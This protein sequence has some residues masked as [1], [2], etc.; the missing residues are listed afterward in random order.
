M[1]ETFMLMNTANTPY[2]GL[3]RDIL[4]SV[5]VPDPPPEDGHL[6]VIFYS[7][8]ATVD[9]QSTG[10]DRNPQNLANQGYI[11]IAPQHQDI[12]AILT[13][14]E[15]H[16]NRP[17]STLERV[18]DFN[19]LG[20]AAVVD[21]IMAEFNSRD[22]GSTVY[23]AD[24]T[25]PI[26]AGH[27]QGAFTA[28]MLIGV[29]SARP[30]FSGLQANPFFEAAVLFSPQ[31]VPTTGQEDPGLL[32]DPFF[33]PF[34]A[35]R[36]AVREFYLRDRV[37]ND[38][39]G[40]YWT[41]LYATTDSSGAVVASSWDNVTIPVLVITGT[42]D[43]G[44]ALQNYTHR[45]DGFDYSNQP[46]R[47]LV[48]V[49]GADHSE[50]GG[51]YAATDGG[52]H[53]TIAGIAGDFLDAY[54]LGDPG[55]QAI[56]NDVDGLAVRYPLLRE[57]FEAAGTGNGGAANGAGRVFGDST[58]ETLEGS[59]TDDIV[60]GRGG[61]DTLFG[62]GGDD[63]LIGG[64]GRDTMSGGLGD[65]S[66]VFAP[67][68]TGILST[69]RDRISDFDDF[70]NDSIDLSAFGE[71]SYMG[72]GAFTG[73]NQVRVVSSG[74][75]VLIQINTDGDASAEAVIELLNT[76]LSQVGIDDFFP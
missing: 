67:G 32:L 21:A 47:H 70:G 4:V 13:T 49:E 31:G 29:Q 57:I 20:N 5:F 60:Y 15:F 63:F 17:L 1:S 3:H 6:P 42:E 39:D 50:M 40:D 45:R 14:D 12:G 11:V 38:N 43:A 34:G 71:L 36:Q 16:R 59:A 8:G 30:E 62:A 25:T 41:G 18:E 2:A 66:F 75:S 26:I 69:T 53:E 65:D 64:A 24:L 52:V 22:T 58:A 35:S 9:I 56:I 54:V 28:Q 27:S 7:H 61:N 74:S 10:A 23:S 48:V 44:D 19:D 37:Q 33:T 46:G 51:F 73:A 68:E 55:A 76:S 72:T